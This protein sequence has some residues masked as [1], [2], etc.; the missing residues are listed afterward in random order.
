MTTD[1]RT[2]LLKELADETRLRV[3]DRLGHGGAATVSEL[4]NELQAPLPRL[5][6]HLRR[7]R[8]AGLVQV[9]RSGR[10]A[11]YALADPGLQALLPLLDRLTGR[12]LATSAAPPR[13]SEA[14]RTCYDHLA[15]RLGVEL[16]DALRER[17]ALRDLPDGTVELGPAAAKTFSALGV[18]LEEVERGRRRFAFE[19]FDATEHSSHLAG[20]LGDELAGAL[21]GRE[22]LVRGDGREVTVAPAGKRGLRRVLDLC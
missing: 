8:E 14:A 17:Q 4:S 6:N 10:H 7:L 3:I 22:W 2:A 16:Y 5:S 12:T 21:F 19:C 1:P 13:R 15:G 18:E 20:A 11:I 9:E